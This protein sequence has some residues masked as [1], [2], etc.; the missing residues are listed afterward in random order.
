MSDMRNEIMS[1]LD[2]TVVSVKVENID[3]V[4]NSEVISVT[5]PTT[6]L[7]MGKTMIVDSNNDLITVYDITINVHTVV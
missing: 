7:A 6:R 5:D 2:N 4:S 3:T 1:V